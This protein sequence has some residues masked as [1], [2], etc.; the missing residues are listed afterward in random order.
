MACKTED[1]SRVDFG[2]GSRHPAGI[3]SRG[4]LMARS[5]PAPRS[6]RRGGTGR[7]GTRDRA[8]ETP[9]TVARTMKSTRF[10]FKQR[11]MLSAATSQ[12]QAHRPGGRAHLGLSGFGTEK[13]LCKHQGLPW[14]TMTG[15]EL[16]EADATTAPPGD[17]P[18]HRNGGA[19]R[20]GQWGPKLSQVLPVQSERGPR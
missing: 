5:P 14:I 16:R 20:A 19:W 6:G 1:V 13:G 10:A 17:G 7:S 12:S 11:I 8:S 4:V 2:L 9:T 3:G 18:C 15:T